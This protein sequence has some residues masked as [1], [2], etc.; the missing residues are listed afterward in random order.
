MV[1]KT[2]KAKSWLGRWKTRIAGYAIV[3]VGALQMA[4]PHLAAVLSPD[5]YNRLMIGLGLLVALFGHMNAR[6]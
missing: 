2:A 1:S 5:S 3:V 4:G 6:K